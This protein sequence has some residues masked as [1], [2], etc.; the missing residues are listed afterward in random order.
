MSEKKKKK[1]AVISEIH[2]LH[3]FINFRV[4]NPEVK[5][6]LNSQ[7]EKAENMASSNIDEAKKIIKEVRKTA[8]VNLS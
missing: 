5:S 4:F 8:Y 3:N 7:L 2:R 1:E 6:K